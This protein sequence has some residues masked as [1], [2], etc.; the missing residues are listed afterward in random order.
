MTRT[1]RHL[2]HRLV[3][4]NAAAMFQRLMQMTF[5]AEMFEILLVYLDDIVIFSKSIKEH[6]KRLDAVFTKLREFGLKLE[7]KKCNFFKKE[8]LYIGH[9]IGADEVAT[10]PSK[11][12]VVEKWP[13]PKTL[14]DLRSFLGFASYYRRYVPNFTQ[15]SSPLHRVVT[16]ACKEGKGKRRTSKMYNLEKC[17][18][19]ECETAFNALKTALTTTPVL[20]F[21]D[22]NMFRDYLLGGTF[23]VYTDNNPLTYLNKKVKLPA[24]EQRWAASLAPLN[25]DRRYRPGHC[26]ANA[27]GLSRLS[28]CNKACINIHTVEASLAMV[29]QTSHLPVNLRVAV[30][31]ESE[32]LLSVVNE[33]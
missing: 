15:I 25:F 32:R 3:Y 22:Y 29:T 17:W 24:V 20:G 18:T 16:D 10:D 19:D 11:I 23:T 1:K 31:E 27:D 5:S 21:T 2:Q 28:E 13:V 8:V 26:N 6:L 33:R 30:M 7:L 4:M 12:A 14:K 9:L